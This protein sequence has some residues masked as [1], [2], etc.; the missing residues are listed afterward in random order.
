MSSCASLGGAPNHPVWYYS[1]VANPRV[2][3]QDGPARR[4]YQAREVHSGKRDL[5]RDV[6]LGVV[7]VNIAGAV[8]GPEL[9]D[10]LPDRGGIGDRLCP[11]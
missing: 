5:H 2:E 3:L 8:L 9:A 6:P 10:D 7:P 4:D 1:L 11:S